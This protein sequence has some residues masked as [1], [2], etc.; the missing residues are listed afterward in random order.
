MV[1]PSVNATNTA[2][3]IAFFYE[4]SKAGDVHITPT[5]AVMIKLGFS[6]F[7][8]SLSLNVLIVLMIVIR[9]ILHLR[10]LREAL[11]TSSGGQHFRDVVR[12]LVES[13]TLY[14][15]SFML[16]FALWTAKSLVQNAFWPILF[17]TQVGAAFTVP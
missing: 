1:V 3:G 10:R 15:V 17:E 5:S 14:A 16:T 8:V 7:T 9:L 6:Y 13:C 11:G 12:M 4:C 2:T